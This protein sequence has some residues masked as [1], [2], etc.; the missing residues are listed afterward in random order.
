MRCKFEGTLVLNDVDVERVRPS[1]PPKY[2]ASAV[3]ESDVLRIAARAVQIYAEKH[4]RPPHV[5]IKQAAE[6]LGLSRNTV[7]KM[8][9]TGMFKLNMCGLIPI[10]QVDAALLPV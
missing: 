5:T 9:H 3:I 8:V 2:H 1:E 10:E 6:M 7:S 4:P